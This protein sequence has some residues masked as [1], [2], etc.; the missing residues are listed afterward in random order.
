MK[1]D[2]QVAVIGGLLVL[3]LWW[4][5]EH[6]PLLLSWGVRFWHF[7]ETSPTALLAI[8]LS[9]FAVAALSFVAIWMVSYF[10]SEKYAIKKR[11]RQK[12]EFLAHE[13]RMGELNERW[14]EVQAK[15][16][17]SNHDT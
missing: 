16:R 6:I 2:Y 1:R 7:L 8:R 14:Q 10:R 12:Q 17:K 13:K 11:W 9:L 3:A 15:M 4:P 5:V